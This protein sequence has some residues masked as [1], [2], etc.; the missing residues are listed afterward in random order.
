MQFDTSGGIFKICEWLYRL[1]LLQIIAIIFTLAG[2][3]IFGIFPAITAMFA[4]NSKWLAQEDFSITKTFWEAFKQHFVKSNVVGLAVLLTGTALYIDFALLQNF[5]GIFYYLI[6]SSSATVFV[7]SIIV[8]LYVFGLMITFPD[9]RLIDLIKRAIQISTLFP[10][11]TVW[12]GLSLIS[13]L[14]ICWVIPGI[15]FLFMGSGLSCI[16]MYFSRFA[17]TRIESIMIPTAHTSI[18]KERGVIHGK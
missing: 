16:A 5:S 13:F 10:L 2:G 12:M 6:L 8:L 1:A 17:L 18:L 9:S 3:I 14:F 11:Q 4:L 15:G 7:L